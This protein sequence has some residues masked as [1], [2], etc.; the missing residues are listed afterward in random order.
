VALWILLQKKPPSDRAGGFLGNFCLLPSLKQ[1]LLPFPHQTRRESIKIKEE[2]LGSAVHSALMLAQ[3]TA[4]RQV[5]QTP[6]F[7]YELFYALSFQY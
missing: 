4:R 2:K 3:N 5:L 1:T 6:S 7:E